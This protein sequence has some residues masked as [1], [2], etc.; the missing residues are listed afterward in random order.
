M[1]RSCIKWIILFQRVFKTSKDNLIDVLELFFPQAF[2]WSFH[3]IFSVSFKML[4]Q[5]PNKKPVLINEETQAPNMTSVV[6]VVSTLFKMCALSFVCVL[7]PVVDPSLET[8]DFQCGKAEK[9]REQF[10]KFQQ[11]TNFWTFLSISSSFSNVYSIPFLVLLYFYFLSFS[12]FHPASLTCFLWE[13]PF[14]SLF[15]IIIFRLSLITLKH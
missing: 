6:S 15:S 7:Q 13:N 2:S 9:W 5:K 3:V 14:C 11:C 8:I 4:S 1:L 12:L 10:K